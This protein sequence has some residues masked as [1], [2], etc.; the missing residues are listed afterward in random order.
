MPQ[1]G[2]R[3]I[4]T[5]EAMADVAD[6]QAREEAEPNPSRVQRIIRVLDRIAISMAHT[7]I[8]M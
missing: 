1:E 7:E 3:I 8:D 2:M 6:Q 5:E 4:P